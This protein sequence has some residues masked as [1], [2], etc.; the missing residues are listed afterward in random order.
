MKDIYLV[1]DLLKG[2]YRSYTTM[3]AI[4]KNEDVNYR[5]LYD[6]FLKKDFYCRNGIYISKIK[7]I[8]SCEK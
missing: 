4:S 3:S 5:G 2:E 7:L 1:N 6:N 8:N